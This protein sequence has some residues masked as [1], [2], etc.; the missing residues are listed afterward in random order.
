MSWLKR[1]EPLIA[2]AIIMVVVMAGWLLMPRIMLLVS[3]GGPIAGVAIAIAF[4]LAFFGVLWLR[5]RHQ[6]R[7]QGD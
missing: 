6:R 5:A 2:A 3:G 4:I 7:T 1:H